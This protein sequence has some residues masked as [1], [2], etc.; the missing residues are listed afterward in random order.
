MVA[1]LQRIALKTLIVRL[2]SYIVSF[3]E[4]RSLL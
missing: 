3:L 1:L 4:Q 2:I